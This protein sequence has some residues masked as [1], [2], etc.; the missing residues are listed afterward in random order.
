[1]EH[2]ICSKLTTNHSFPFFKSN[3]LMDGRFIGTRAIS[4]GGPMM[5]GI[6]KGF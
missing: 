5:V 4:K 2:L 3:G 6:A 1:M